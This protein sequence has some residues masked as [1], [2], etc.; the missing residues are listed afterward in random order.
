[1][2]LIIIIV[3]VMILVSKLQTCRLDKKD[4]DL[5]VYVSVVGLALFLL[6]DD[7]LLNLAVLGAFFCHLRLEVLVQV[8]RPNHV[9]QHHHSRLQ[10]NMRQKS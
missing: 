3:V 2:T 6:V 4:K 5:D 8:F 9:L 7:H 10:Q 1:M